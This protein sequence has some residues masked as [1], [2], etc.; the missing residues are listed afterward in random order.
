MKNKLLLL[1]ITTL[2]MTL[3]TN[4]VFSQALPPPLPPPAPTGVPFGAVEYL[5]AGL[6]VYAY[7]KFKN[8]KKINS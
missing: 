7:K 3:I 4:M 6:G 5:L 1:S 2:V 8:S